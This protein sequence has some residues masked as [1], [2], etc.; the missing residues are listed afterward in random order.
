M[1][2]IAS[3]GTALHRP[4]P[5]RETAV[6]AERQALVA[7][8]WLGQLHWLAIHQHRIDLEP[9]VAAGVALDQEAA[10]SGHRRDIADRL[11]EEANLRPV[12]A[13]RRDAVDLLGRTEA[14][15][16]QH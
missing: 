12:R 16:D 6:I 11:L 15:G 14:G 3:T 5:S 1:V 7:R 9:F 4:R 10:D 2:T 8:A 13:W